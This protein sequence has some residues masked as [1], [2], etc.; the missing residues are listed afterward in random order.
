MNSSPWFFRTRHKYCLD[1]GH[2]IKFEWSQIIVTVQFS[3]ERWQ[4]IGGHCSSEILP[5]KRKNNCS[6]MTKVRLE[7]D[8]PYVTSMIILFLY[9]SPDSYLCSH[10]NDYYPGFRETKKQSDIALFKNR[11]Q[12]HGCARESIRLMTSLRQ[13]DLCISVSL[14]VVCSHSQIESQVISVPNVQNYGT[15]T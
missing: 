7:R 3:T 9:V 6:L 10:K 13:R 12:Y 8:T 1:H 4:K 5:Q 15:V 14:Q 2:V 11:W